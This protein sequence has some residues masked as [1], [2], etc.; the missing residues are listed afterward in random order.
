[1]SQALALTSPIEI[2]TP[3]LGTVERWILAIVMLELPI[4]IDAYLFFNEDI[5]QYAAIGGLNISV[6][7]FCL[8]GLYAIRLPELLLPS[9]DD[10]G[11][12]WSASWPL[13]LY[14]AAAAASVLVAYDRTVAVFYLSLLI[15]NFLLFL[16]IVCFVRGRSDIVFTVGML[17]LGLAVEGAIMIALRVYNESVELPLVN[18]RVD[19]EFGS[20]VAG[21][22]GSPVTAST[23]LSLLLP[24]ALVLW[25]TPVRR[26]YRLIAAGASILGTVALVL[27][28]AR[29]GM[30]TF[31]LSAIVVCAL[32]WRRGWVP[33][34]VPLAIVVAIAAACVV[35]AEALTTRLFG[36]DQG[37]AA[38]R[39]P[40]NQLALNMISDHALMGVGANNCATAGHIYSSTSQF[41]SE[42]YSTI[43]NK[44]LL[45]WVETGI[46]GLLGFISFLALTLW[47]GWR[48]WQMRDRVLSPVALAFTVAILAQ[49]VHMAV[50]IF[51]S[52][53]QEQSLWIV[54]ALLMSISSAGSR[55]RYAH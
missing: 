46:V 18:L 37:S 55:E 23:Y 52:R 13:L 6:A 22:I 11:R 7:T 54:A 33:T 12:G 38:S 49:M 50:D 44:Y 34:W 17:L 29:G 42:W 26:V 10:R 19:T 24:A 20:R 1:M 28:L 8:L 5:A 21:T 2:S 36:D 43:H 40:L 27:T 31:A 51:N 35:N 53:P 47:R 14:L 3:R 16:Y 41:R 4:Q 9:P 39:L 15:Q 30:G 48:G 45:V 25:A 32:C